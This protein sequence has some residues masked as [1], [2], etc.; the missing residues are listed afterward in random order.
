MSYIFTDPDPSIKQRPGRV[1]YRPII[2]GIKHPA[3][4]GLT[5]VKRRDISMFKR[6][7]FQTA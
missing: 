7:D 2:L 3:A 5:S 6:F 1:I 4:F